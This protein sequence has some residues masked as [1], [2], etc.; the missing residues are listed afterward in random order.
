MLDNINLNTVQNLDLTT[1]KIKKGQFTHCYIFN[2]Q[3]FVVLHSIDILKECQALWMYNHEENPHL[4]TIKRIHHEWYV[5]P[6]YSPLTAK[7]KTA[8]A[9]YKKMVALQYKFDIPFRSNYYI[10]MKYAQAVKTEIDENVGNALE[11][12][13]DNGINA[14]DAFCLDLKKVNFSVDENGNLILRDV[15]AD[16]KCVYPSPVMI[17]SKVL[18]KIVCGDDQKEVNRISN[19]G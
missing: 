9:Q 17:S 7:H 8:Y 10:C 3:P 1:A 14:T 16:R 11:E 4:P 18:L 15:L 6:K 12:L 13:L 5:M 19:V 2:E